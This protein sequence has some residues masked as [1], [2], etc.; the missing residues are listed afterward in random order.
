MIVVAGEALIDLVAVD[1]DGG[2]QAVVGGL[3]CPSIAC[4]VA[5]STPPSTPYRW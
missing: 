3:A 5:R 2:Y 1:R 4:T